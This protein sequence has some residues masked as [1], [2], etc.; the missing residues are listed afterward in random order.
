MIY[1]LVII[2]CAVSGVFLLADRTT[3]RTGWA[4]IVAAFCYEASWWWNWP[5]EW[6]IGP[7]PSISFL[8]GYWS[9][10]VGGLALLLY[11]EPVLGKRYERWYFIGFAIWILGV[12]AFIVAV[13]KPDWA[14]WNEQAWWP[15]DKGLFETAS[16]TFQDRRHRA[17]ADTQCA[18]A[19]DPPV[20]RPGT[21]RRPSGVCCRDSHRHHG[22]HPCYVDQRQP[23]PR[24]T[25]A[26]AGCGERRDRHNHAER[27]KIIEI[28]AGPGGPELP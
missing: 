25:S 7:A 14:G 6:E 11:P 19:G 10:A 8:F 23:F 16:D 21:V 9:F 3:G 13:S 5:P 18:A 27:H 12:K 20:A 1:F 4:M 2:S 22:Q 24:G 15:P 17:G 26:R 28:L